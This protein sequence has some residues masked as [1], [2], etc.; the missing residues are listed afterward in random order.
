[1]KDSLLVY[2]YEGQASPAGSIG[3]C[4]LLEADND[5][6]FLDNLGPKFKTLAEVCGGKEEITEVKPVPRAPLNTMTTPRTVETT[7][8]LIST[9]STQPQP[10]PQPLPQT[11][12]MTQN[13][14][15][16][17]VR[18]TTR[19]TKTVVDGVTSVGGGVAGQGQTLL[20]QQQPPVY[21]TTAPVMQ[22]MHYIM[23][24]QMQNTVYLANSPA[25]TTNMQGMMLVNGGTLGA[26]Q[27][28]IVQGQSVGGGGGAV[29]QTGT[30]PQGVMVVEGQVPAGSQQMLQGQTYL[31]QGGTLKRGLSASQSRLVVEGQNMKGE[32]S[33]VHNTG[34]AFNPSLQAGSIKSVVHKKKTVTTEKR[35]Q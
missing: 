25:T 1:M 12:T 5:L 28:L 26:T 21:Y 13:T 6:H 19:K 22:P 14:E 9:A 29:I 3:C 15:H 8:T 35:T 33:L 24:P 30:L 10:K 31:V 18:N 32:G 20:V 16:S 17:T 4:S 34:T 27:G 2:D 7:T 11:Q 23:Q